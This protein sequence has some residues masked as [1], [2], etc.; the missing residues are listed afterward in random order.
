M[1]NMFRPAKSNM[2]TTM[3][4]R[5]RGYCFSQ[6]AFVRRQ[7]PTTLPLNLMF[8]LPNDLVLGR[9]YSKLWYL[10]YD[11]PTPI[12]R[13]HKGPAAEFLSKH[14]PSHVSSRYRNNWA[15]HVWFF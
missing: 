8:A 5:L 13:K 3:R 10:A 15:N 7:T 12:T 1:A 14:I 6:G 9:L 11:A 4:C 2:L